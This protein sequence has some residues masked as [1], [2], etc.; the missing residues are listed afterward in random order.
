MSIAK[1]S[2]HYS[3]L[4]NQNNVLK[5]CSKFTVEHPC[6]R[7]TSI[8]LKS[9]F[10]ENTLRHGCSPVNLL[11]IFRPSFPNKHLWRAASAHF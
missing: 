3:C 1:S 10:I 2:L 6:R 11:H 9:I 7:V 4:E 8:K 5:I